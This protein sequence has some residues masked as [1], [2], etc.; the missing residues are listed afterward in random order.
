MRGRGILFVLAPALI[1]IVI[2]IG[3]SFS[4]HKAPSIT[5]GAQELTIATR[6]GSIVKYSDITAVEEKDEPPANLTKVRGDD[7]GTVLR[8]QFRSGGQTA[9]VYIDTTHP[10]FIYLTTTTGLVVFNQDDPSR[11]RYIYAQLR[12]KVK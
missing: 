7:D 6:Y 4:T 10:P 9:M 8:G 5:V 1:V 3:S 2:V 12:A 11:T